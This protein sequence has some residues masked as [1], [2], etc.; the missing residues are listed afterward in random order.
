[1]DLATVSSNSQVHV[2]GRRHAQSPYIKI[3][4]RDILR[5]EMTT[6]T[7]ISSVGNISA[8]TAIRA[9]EIMTAMDR[10]SPPTSYPLLQYP[11]AVLEQLF[12]LVGTRMM[13]IIT[14]LPVLIAIGREVDH[15]VSTPGLED[16]PGG[17]W[18]VT[19]THIHRR[20]T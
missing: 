2:T 6:M 4:M 9:A 16:I 14:L 15:I 10:P 1:M 7:P 12:S 18:R 8:P 11:A 17:A 13:S 5:I 20:T 19:P 3:M